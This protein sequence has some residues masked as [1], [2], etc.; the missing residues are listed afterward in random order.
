MCLGAGDSSIWYDDRTSKGL[1]AT[2]VDFVNISDTEIRLRCL[3][4][5]HLEFK[6][7]VDHYS[8]ASYRHYSSWECR[9]HGKRQSY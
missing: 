1:L 8:H 4:S 6:H 7:F 3:E 9:S 2:L 5:W